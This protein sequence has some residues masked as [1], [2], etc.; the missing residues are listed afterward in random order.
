MSSGRGRGFALV[1]VLF[2]V[3]VATSALL[4]LQASAFRQAISGR[5]AVGRLRAEWAA[6]AGLEAT[7][8]RLAAVTEAADTSFAYAAVDEMTGVSRGNIFRGWDVTGGVAVAEWSIEHFDGERLFEGPADAHSK[9]NISKMTREDLLELPG[10]TEDVA[11]AVIDWVDADDLV[12]EFG[13]EGGYYSRREPP[14]EPRNGRMRSIEELELV[15]GV[16]SELVRGE[17]W[18]LN[19][20]LD[21][22]EDDGDAS[23]PPDNSDGVLDAGWSGIVTT[24]SLDQGLAESGD[25]R[26]Y[27]PAATPAELSARVDGLENA[28]ARA[29]VSAA[30]NAEDGEGLEIFLGA[31]LRALA[32]ATGEFSD[33]EL[34]QIRPLGEEQ[35][36][37]IFAELTMR[38]P[39]LGPAA[40]RV[41]LNLVRREVLDYVTSLR[42]DPGTADRLI[43]LRDSRPDG[44]TSIVDLLDFASPQQVAALYRDVGVRSVSFVVTSRGTDLSTGIGVELVATIDR[45]RLPIVISEMRER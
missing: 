12:T 26:V 36:R 28:Q 20:R 14:V 1:V 41:N 35:L 23:W 25:E 44:F 8:A 22:N 9:V 45:T 32:F 10:M 29:M 11:A 2:A 38:D 18:N 30:A 6:R 21:A 5:E 42:E 31:D 37:D 34:G 19:G 17:D 3:G 27:L 15:A 24:E 7:I 39:D 43:F 4:L 40:G 16:D 13:A 33:V